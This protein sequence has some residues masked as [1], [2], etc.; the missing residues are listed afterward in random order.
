[1]FYLKNLQNFELLITR[2]IYPPSAEVE[3]LFVIQPPW[4][5][6]VPSLGQPSAAA[7][8]GLGPKVC[9]KECF[10]LIG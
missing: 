2:N 1:M 8:G 3:M 7:P 6:L 5:A 9:F 10:D 4:E